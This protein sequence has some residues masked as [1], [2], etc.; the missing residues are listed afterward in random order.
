MASSSC[1]TRAIRPTFGPHAACGMGRHASVT[2]RA[3]RAGDTSAKPRFAKHVA[4]IGDVV[5]AE[6]ARLEEARGASIKRLL[7]ATASFVQDEVSLVVRSST[8]SRPE[9]RS[10]SF[11]R[12]ADLDDDNDDDTDFSDE[13]DRV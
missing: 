7:M 8:K 12:A 2:V 4:M 11:V 5:R 1:A 13:E 10:S 3:T 6:R 9:P